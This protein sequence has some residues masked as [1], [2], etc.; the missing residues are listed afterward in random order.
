VR[1]GGKYQ[2]RVRKP[3]LH[4]DA[5]RESV[6]RDSNGDKLLLMPLTILKGQRLALLHLLLDSRDGKRLPIW[7]HKLFP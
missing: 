3:D 4:C 1:V 7:E 5:M 2:Y 6:G